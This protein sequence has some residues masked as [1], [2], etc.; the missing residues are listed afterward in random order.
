[1][2]YFKPELFVAFNSGDA[3]AANRASQAWDEAVTAYDQYLK[4]IR[5]RLPAAV[6]KLSKLYLHDATYLDFGEDSPSPENR[7]AHLTVRRDGQPLLLLYF[8][9]DTPS[10]TPAVTDP[11]FSEHSVHWLYDELEL[12]GPGDV[13]HEILFSNGCIYRFRFHHLALLTIAADSE[14]TDVHGQQ[15]RSLLPARRRRKAATA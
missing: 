11:V 14:R 4:S 6:Q 1:M 8:L 10:V 13:S 3:R 15:R 7:V 12:R 9:L 5:R 2:K